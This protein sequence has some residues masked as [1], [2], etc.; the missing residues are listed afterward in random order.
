M[1]LRYYISL[2]MGIVIMRESRSLITLSR[3]PFIMSVLMEREKEGEKGR[4]ITR[5]FSLLEL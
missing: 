2:Y 4:I 5:S 1:S 3:D